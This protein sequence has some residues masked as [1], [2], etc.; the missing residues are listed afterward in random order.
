MQFTLCNSLYALHSMHFTLC[1]S[2][3]ALDSMH[4]TLC[5]SLYALHSTRFTLCTSLYALNSTHFTLWTSLYVVGSEG[6]ARKN[7][8]RCFREF[9]SLSPKKNYRASHLLLG[10][11]NKTLFCSSTSTS[12]LHDCHTVAFG[13]SVVITTTTRFPSHAQV[14]HLGTTCLGLVCLYEAQEVLETRAPSPRRAQLQKLRT[15]P[16]CSPAAP[17]A[18]VEALKCPGES[19]SFAPRA[20][21]FRVLG[22][23]VRGFRV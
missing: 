19:D 18:G 8:S 15:H 16:R 20:Q 6:S 2:H 5:T 21:G 12:C 22:F 1:T 23:S 9:R 17:A 3:Y 11:I 7:P 10:G 14:R 13:Q 4:F